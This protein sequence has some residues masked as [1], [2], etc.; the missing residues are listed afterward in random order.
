MKDYVSF[1][2][3]ISFD[4][5]KQDKI[6]IKLIDDIKIFLSFLFFIIVYTIFGSLR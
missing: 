6:K 2:E 3:R 1:K 4:T 5:K